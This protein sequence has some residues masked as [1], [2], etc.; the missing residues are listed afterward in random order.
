MKK[1]VLMICPTFAPVAGGSEIHASEL[2]EY[3][4]GRGHGVYL[5]ACTVPLNGRYSVVE[6]RD[7][8]WIR[9]IPC[10][11]P[12][13]LDQTGDHPIIFPFMV[14]PPLLFH[15]F[16]FLLRHRREIDVIYAQSVTAGLV[17]AML[18]TIFRKRRVVT[19]HGEYFSDNPYHLQYH[20]YAMFIKWV[21]R[22]FDKV[23]T[24]N[25]QSR[26]ELI[27]VGVEAEKV[28]VAP[29]W[30]NQR[31]FSPLDRKACKA[32]LGWEEKFVVLFVGRFV[33]DKGINEMIE[34]A[35]STNRP[36]F[37]AFAGD[38]P[39]DERIASEAKSKPNI[40]YIGRV[41]HDR[42]PIYYNAADL[43]LL[44]SRLE[45]PS[46]VIME[47]LSC[48]TPVIGANRGW[49]PWVMDPSVGVIIEP[50]AEEI[51]RATEALFDDR[52]KL[53]KLMA[54]CRGY[55]EGR[56]SVRNAEVIEASYYE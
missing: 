33:E 40:L 3:L 2:C 15:S 11:N 46:R 43:I 16:V 39:M 4:S 10:L 50:T 19:T 37:F 41:D 9:R 18:A 29:R 14:I 5:I 56:F 12:K 55:A 27:N 1:T 54:N 51:N 20:K 35:K 32:E 13:L 22:R 47:A 49:I 26:D 52:S 34:A 31:V 48:G 30:V 45:G 38:G 28:V 17:A 36:V 24:V 7:N 42:L 8:V 53:Q 23:L 21:F 25:D 6:T 44:P